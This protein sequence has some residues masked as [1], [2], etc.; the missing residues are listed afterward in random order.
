MI[1][2]IFKSLQTIPHPISERKA[3][4][5]KES[6]NR[7]KR[8]TRSQQT[9]RSDWP[10]S[11]YR[12]L[13]KERAWG[14]WITAPTSKFCIKLFPRLFLNEISFPRKYFHPSSKNW[15]LGDL[16]HLTRIEPTRKAK[17]WTHVC[18]ARK[19]RFV[20]IFL[21]PPACLLWD[22]DLKF[23]R[24][25][26]CLRAQSTCYICLTEWVRPLLWEHA[27][28]S[29]DPQPPLKCQEHDSHQ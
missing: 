17:T 10:S 26:G 6:E 16:K 1:T 14:I 13:G 15:T 2:L 18:W 21:P 29:S 28:Q 24:R 12:S 7:K 11:S 19:H 22:N 5:I 27:N 20:S 4:W 8:H 3:S 23:R 9:W 25:K